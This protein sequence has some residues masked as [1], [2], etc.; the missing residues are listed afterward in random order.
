[1]R[2]STSGTK[3]A[4]TPDEPMVIRQFSIQSVSSPSDTLLLPMPMTRCLLTHK[5]AIGT[6]FNVR[7]PGPY[8][9]SVLP[10]RTCERCGTMQRGI[11]KALWRDISW[12]T[13]RERTYIKSQQRLIVR[14]PSPR[15]DQLAHTLGLRRSRM[16]DGGIRKTLCAHLK[17]AG[18]TVSANHTRRFSGLGPGHT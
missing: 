15:L 5:W 9:K 1:M 17:L 14:R 18:T 2:F 7:S 8:V 16:S 3:V 12:E 10:Y 13:I 11:F 4:V 6:E